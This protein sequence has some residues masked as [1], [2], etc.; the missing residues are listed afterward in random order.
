MAVQVPDILI[1]GKIKFGS[2]NVS[3]SFSSGS[4]VYNGT[5]LSFT[6]QFEVVPQAAGYPDAISNPTYA[7]AA[8]IQVG[9]KFALPTG[10]IYDV[11][12][13]NA[14]STDSASVGLIDTN[15][16]VFVNS[17]QD[18]PDNL[19]TEESYGCFF[20]MVSGSAKLGNLQSQASNFGIVSYWISDVL[21]K[22]LEQAKTDSNAAIVVRDNIVLDSKI[23]LIRFIVS[24][25]LILIVASSIV[26]N[27]F[28]RDSFR[29][30]NLV[31]T[32][33]FR[34]VVLVILLIY[35]F[36]TSFW[37]SDNVL[38]LSLNFSNIIL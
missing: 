36:N 22:V 26:G 11:V 31:S 27:N 4:S 13:I 2:L 9:M 1:L 18:P 28:K 8:D 23:G 10:Q 35:S 17:N 5:P 34:L 3:Q 14:H 15:L 30:V 21:D 19:P 33:F 24:F 20:P 32:Y 12:S 29:Y 16:N 37:S 7:D 6:T 38:N 25:T